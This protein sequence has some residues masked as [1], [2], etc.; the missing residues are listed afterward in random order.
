MLYKV[1]AIGGNKTFID[2]QSNFQSIYYCQIMSALLIN[3]LLPTSVLL[4]SY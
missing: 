2:I 3:V 4:Y 1:K